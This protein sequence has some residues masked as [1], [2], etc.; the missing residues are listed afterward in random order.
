[1]TDFRTILLDPNLMNSMYLWINRILMQSSIYGLFS[2]KWE[3]IFWHE[4]NSSTF[5]KHAVCLCIFKRCTIELCL[6]L[7]NRK[8]KKHN[9]IGM[10]FKILPSSLMFTKCLPEIGYSLT[11]WN[12][13]W[14]TKCTL[15]SFNCLKCIALC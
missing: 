10:I 2:L 11:F 8:G 9:R 4:H 3:W 7:I 12:L 13:Y 14:F 6:P 1:M 15:N 5:P